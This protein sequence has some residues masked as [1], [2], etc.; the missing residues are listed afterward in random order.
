MKSRILK[1]AKEESRGSIL[2]IS[3]LKVRVRDLWKALVKE[4]FIF[5]FKNT[6]EVMAMNKLETVYRSWT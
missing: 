5:R 3:E 2:K 1:H 4:N 6:R